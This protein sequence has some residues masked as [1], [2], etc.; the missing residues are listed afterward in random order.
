MRPQ[1]QTS[2]YLITH[3]TDQGIVQQRSSDGYINATE[4]CHAAGKRWHNYVRNETTGNFLRALAAKTRISVLDL[5]QEV[6]DKNGTASTWV[7]PKVA[8]HLAQW[9]SADFAVQ[10]SE[11]VYEWMSGQG[12]PREPAPLPSHLARYL[13]NDPNVHPGYFSVLQETALNLFGPLHNVGFIIPADWVPDISVGRSFCKWLR[14]NKGMDTNSLPTYQH[15]YPDDGRVVEAKLY[16]D[17]LLADFRTWF[18][19]VWLP[20]NGV[21]YFKR[22]NPDSLAYLDKHPALAIAAPSSPPRIARRKKAA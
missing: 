4:L 5:N 17:T 18:R 15:I 8:I 6:R 3:K 16:P 14:E 11:W 20:V 9:L 2:L 22:K 13:A 21:S 7:H 1:H 19:N 10:V 12:A